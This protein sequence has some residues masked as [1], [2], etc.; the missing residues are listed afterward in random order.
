M[1]RK[2]AKVDD[3]R[4]GAAAGDD[5]LRL[6]LAGE[7]RHLVHVDAVVLPAHLVGHHLEPLAG[8]VHRRAVGE[9]PAALQRQPHVGIAGLHQRH[10][11]GLVGAGARVRL[12]VGEAAVEE[13][14]GAL[15]RQRLHLVHVLAAAVVAV[16]RI[17]LGVLV[18][19]HAAG[20][21][22]HRAGDD[23]L[24]GDQLDLVLLATELATDGAGDQRDRSRPGLRRK[25]S[26]TPP[27]GARRLRWPWDAF[28]MCT[29]SVQA[30]PGSARSPSYHGARIV[31]QMGSDPRVRPL[32]TLTSSGRRR[33]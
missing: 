18:G 12:H 2:A 15:D 20:R 11:G 10:E 31:G 28:R 27:R 9:V 14:L 8:V 17:A 21:L 26:T 23:V 33:S 24:R 13:L 29:S 22:E 7:R 25:S 16:A 1:A 3:A 4:I 30:A 19:E 6:V 32:R 5:H